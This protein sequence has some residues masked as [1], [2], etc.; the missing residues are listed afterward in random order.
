MKFVEIYITIFQD[1]INNFTRQLKRRQTKG[2][3]GC[4]VYKFGWDN[5]SM[6]SK[7]AASRLSILIAIFFHSK[8]HY[9]KIEHRCEKTGFLHMRKQRRS[10]CAAEQRLCFCYIDSTI[11]P[12]P[13]P[14]ISTFCYLLLLYSP[15]CVGPGQKP[16]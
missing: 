12:L 7:I 9:S 13:N 11:T 4:L 8:T 14:E 15:V 2:Y 5:L 6:T 1:D 10:N 16:R 3:E